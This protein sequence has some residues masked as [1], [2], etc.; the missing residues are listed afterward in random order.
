M[1]TAAAPEDP[2]APLVSVILPTRD[3]V[4]MLSRAVDSVLAQSERDLELIVVD[5]ASTDG[6]A[7]YLAAL[8][9][10]DARARSIRNAT[11]G[12]GPAARNTGM[13]QA[14]GDW[15]AF[16]DD[17]D[18]W[19]PKKLERQL[20]TLRASAT[21]V[22]SSCSY[23]VKRASGGSRV[24]TV[25]ENVT[26][27][28][29]FTD[30]LLGGASMCLCSGQVLRQIGGFDVGFR[31]AQDL[32]L[33]V[34]LRQ[35]G[36]IRGCREVLVVHRA[37]SGTRISTNMQSQYLGARH[38]YFK[39]R[40]LMDKVLRRHRVA[41]SC[42]IMSRQPKRGLRHRLRHLWLSMLRSSPAFSLAYAKSSGPRLLRDAICRTVS[43]RKS[44]S[45]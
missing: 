24:V 2:P 25:P 26:L 38:F 41:Y 43:P 31:S 27:R 10:R 30:N 4:D 45:P 40:H 39:H 28:Q 5:D 17:D 8:A 37:H 33:W 3:R 22:A 11:P 16:I 34:R 42:F 29:L 9:A 12:G 18:E 6:T 20:A 44:D 32:D 15:I 7:S 1:S 35:R 13:A 19:L 36:E 14:R 21:A 23:I